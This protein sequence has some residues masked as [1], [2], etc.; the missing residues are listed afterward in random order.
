MFADNN[1]ISWRQLFCQ[2]I[3]SILGAMILFLP[4]RHIQ[5]IGGC[6]ACVI[7][8]VILVFHCFWLTRLTP[9][10]SHLEKYVG[11]MGTKITGGVFVAFYILTAAFVVSLVWEIISQYMITGTSRVLIHLVVI[12]ACG[13]AGSPQIQRRGRMAEFCFPFFIGVLVLMLILAFA[14]SRGDFGT[15]LMQESYMD[16]DTLA[17]DVGI[18]LLAFTCIN[19]VPFL[20]GNVKEK[21]FGGLAGGVSL[22]V[23]F[24]IGTLILLQGSYG[25]AQTNAREWP[26]LS[27]M[28]GIRIPG[29]FVSRMDPVWVALLMLF[30]LFSVGSA[31]FYSNYIVKRTELGIPWYV[32]YGLVFVVSLLR[33]GDKGVSDF[34]MICVKY[35]FAP[36]IFLWNLFLAWKIRRQRS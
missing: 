31:F 36:V 13:M 14:Q 27:L 20:L 34:Y 23:V 2:M 4:G 12:L 26:M 3:L 15:Y 16:V 5:G 9:A 11:D 19:G 7:A 35:F 1:Q 30:L 29:G 18:L 22:V 24:L 28:A 6:I 25:T 32:I 10:Y 33:F 17:R 8:L 21:R